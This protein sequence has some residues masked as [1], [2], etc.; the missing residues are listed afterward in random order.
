MAG[1]AKRRA[2][3]RKREE[4]GMEGRGEIYKVTRIV[5][6]TSKTAQ[7]LKGVQ[8]PEMECLR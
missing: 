3:E 8:C 2:E 7:D 5:K 4:R 6:S 1:E